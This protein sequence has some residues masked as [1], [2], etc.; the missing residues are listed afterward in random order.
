MLRYN[1]V[2]LLM[3]IVK[4]IDNL[5]MLKEERNE[6]LYDSKG[7]EKMW[8]FLRFVLDLLIL[9]AKYG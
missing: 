5:E 2:E 7:C 4:G 9:K 8:S 3:K 1:V 6:C